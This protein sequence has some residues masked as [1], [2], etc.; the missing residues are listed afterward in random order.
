ML[1]TIYILSDSIGNT[2]L[3][4]ARAVAGQFGETEPR[5]EV[6][7][8]VIDF[9]QVTLFLNEKISQAR[10]QGAIAR[11]LVFYTFVDPE[12]RAHVKAFCSAHQLYGVDLMG[13][14]LEMMEMATGVCP[15]TDPGI[16]RQ[17]DEHYFRRM[18]SVNFAVNHDDGR[19]P[20]DLPKADI[21]LLGVS[22]SSKTPIS[23]YLGMDGYK[24]ANVPL[25]LD[26]TPPK[27]LFNCDPTRIFGLVTTPEL[28]ISV[29]K[30]RL[31][32]AGAAALQAA[33][34]Y[35]DPEYVYQDL[36]QARALMRKLGCIVVHTDN[37]AIEEISQEILRYYERQHPLHQQR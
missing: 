25:A 31:R 15:S 11:L 32:V 12:I 18:E 22:R 35:A 13:R 17:V 19:N 33:S 6:L 21:I 8:H 1:P 29:R 37:R 34:K 24:V 30:R 9:S 3:T 36:Q 20:Q 4:L 7:S 27:E 5:T 26:I 14:P 10:A 28:L 23:M 16:F 2:A